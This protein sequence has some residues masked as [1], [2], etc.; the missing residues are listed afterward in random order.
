ML[1]WSFMVLAHWNN[2][3]RI[4]MSPNSDTSSWFRTNKSLIFLLHVACLPVKQQIQIFLVFGLTRA[5]LE[6]TFNRIRGE[7][8]NHSTTD[9]VSM[10]RK[11]S[12]HWFISA[13]YF[14]INLS[15]V[16]TCIFDAV[17]E[18]GGLYDPTQTL[19]LI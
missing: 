4:D 14:L 1:S 16:L 8:A 7:N 9:A 13:L 18:K 11:G 5:G 12:D 17:V 15:V 19:V 3:P 6:H 10:H 2:S